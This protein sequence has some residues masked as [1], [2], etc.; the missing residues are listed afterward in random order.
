LKGLVV[1]DT[2]YG[3]TEKVARHIAS[4][5]GSE[6]SVRAVKV[7]AVSAQDLEHLDVLV[8][9][10]PVHAWRPSRK[11]QAFLKD[12]PDALAGVKAAAFDTRFGPR[13]AGSAADD[14][15]RALLAQGC[16]IVAPAKGFLV[17]GGKGPLAD[18]QLDE[19]EAWARQILE[20]TGPAR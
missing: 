5:L 19:A 20:A 2:N 10:S 14:I 6:E 4:A 16:E 7:D 9:G 18:G 8:A 15:E 1:Y 17:L 13:L 11:M 3:N 12:L